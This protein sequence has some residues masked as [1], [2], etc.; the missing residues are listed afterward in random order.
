[1]FLIRPT[2]NIPVFGGT[3]A[4]RAAAHENKVDYID[5][6]GDIHCEVFVDIPAGVIRI[7][8]RAVDK[9]IIYDTDRI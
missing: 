4:G 7:G 3:I 1:M 6:I 9:N 5:G 8:R 2:G